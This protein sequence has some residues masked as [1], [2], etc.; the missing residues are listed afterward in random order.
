MTAIRFPR[1]SIT[2]WGDQEISLAR[3]KIAW[4]KENREAIQNGVVFRLLS[5]YNGR[6]EAVQYVS[7]PGEK[8]VL[9]CYNLV[10]FHEMQSGEPAAY[11]T[12][13]LKGL[14][15]DADYEVSGLGTF[16]GKSLMERGLDWP[17]K[18]TYSSM[19]ITINKTDNQ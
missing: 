4:Y 8:A 10:A 5:P 13:R 7:Q 1:P 11:S 2:K 6:R 9:F 14:D 19:A 17:V 16:T 18:G 3:T 15:P 12:I